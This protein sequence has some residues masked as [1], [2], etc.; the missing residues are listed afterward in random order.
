MPEILLG[1][2]PVIIVLIVF[3]VPLIIVFMI[4]RA[5]FSNKPEARSALD[6]EETKLMQEVFQGFE[7]MEKRIESLETILYEHKNPSER[8][9][10]HD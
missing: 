10:N 8:K 5:I 9:T 6:P 2:L 1:F 4:L 7:K 3:S